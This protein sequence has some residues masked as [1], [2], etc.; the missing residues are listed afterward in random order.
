MAGDGARLLYL[1]RHAE[2][3]PD[4]FALT[5]RGLLQA[6]HLG[7]RLSHLPL[8]RITH[9]PLVRARDTARVAA[10]QLDVEPDLVEVEAAGDYVPH[11]PAPDEVPAVWAEAVLSH[12]AT[13]PQHEKS[14]GRSLAAQAIALFAGPP[15]PDRERVDVVITHAFTI[16]WLLC[17]ALG[18]PAWRWWGL[19]HC[20]AGLTVIR[21]APERPPSIVVLN[22][23][24]HL[25][26]DLRW[27]GFPEHY[28]A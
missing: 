10:Q 16:G 26:P 4:G 23:L 6:E 21:Y 8:R 12:V 7:R 13:F 19:N 25:P 15:S 2:P 28:Q 18:A 20:H 1:A 27:T 14:R 11:V 24:T 3:E 17:H 9:G 5:S 22:D